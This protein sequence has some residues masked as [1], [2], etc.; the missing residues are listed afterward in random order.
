MKNFKKIILLSLVF[1][2]LGSDTHKIQAGPI[3]TIKTFINKKRFNHN[4]NVQAKKEALESKEYQNFKPQKAGF[5]SGIRN[6][7]AKR[8]KL[9]QLVIEKKKDAGFAGMVA[10]KATPEIQ[11]AAKKLYAKKVQKTS[12]AMERLMDT[13]AAGQEVIEELYSQTIQNAAA[14]KGSKPIF[15]FESILENKIKE[16]KASGHKKLETAFKAKQAAYENNKKFLEKFTQASRLEKVGEPSD[17]ETTY[18]PQKT[19]PLSLPTE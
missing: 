4:V 16:T 12:A 8:Q 3:S 9:N 18:K 5:F 11:K 19:R 10:A 15:K 7:W 2:L 6:W 13:T 1:G 17:V 14:A